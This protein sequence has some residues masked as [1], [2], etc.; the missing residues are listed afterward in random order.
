MAPEV[1]R[2][3]SIREVLTAGGRLFT[4]GLW[5]VFPWVLIA[6][7]TQLIP[8]GNPGGLLDT[9]VTQFFNPV[10]LA[11]AAIFGSAQAFLYAVA[12][13]RL[14]RLTGGADSGTL[15]PA[16]RATP[17]VLIG[18]VVYTILMML[19]LGLGML[20][21]T[22]G[23]VM[24]GPMAALLISLI[25]LAPT[26]AASTAFAFFIYPAVLERRGPLQSLN[27]SSR[28]AR[29]SWARASLIVSVP[30][31]ALLVAWLAGNGMELS[32]SISDTLK[33]LSN[34]PDDI[35]TDQIQALLSG[36]TGQGETHAAWGWRL[37]AAVLGA[38]AWWYTLA[39]CYAEYRDLKSRAE[40]RAH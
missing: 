15:W 4:A 34:M 9:D 26:A 1:A 7:L 17:A 23:L 13:I 10:F 22:G 38:F 18:Y 29:S 20:F 14:A 3:H 16:L 30:A 35:S 32:H 8:N 27:D 21:F 5:S 33:Q 37:L 19:G 11:K 6:E 2:A 36:A 25:P 28:L 39:V 24:L 12:V 40:K 31:V